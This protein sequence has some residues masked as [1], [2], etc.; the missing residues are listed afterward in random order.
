MA[1][2]ADATAIRLTKDENAPKL[3]IENVTLRDA[4]GATAIRLTK[5]ESAPASSVVQADKLYPY[6]QKELVK[7]LAERLGGRV[8]VSGHDLQCV[9]KAFSLDDDPAFSHQAQYSPRKYSEMYVDWL[10]EQLSADPAFFQ[11]AREAAR[12]RSV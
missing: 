12:S 8:A 1:R 5:D 4:P 9:R 2:R 3:S 11:K 6:R 7:R 10:I